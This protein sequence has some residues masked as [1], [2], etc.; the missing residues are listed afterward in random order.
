MEEYAKTNNIKYN[1]IE[2]LCADER[3]IQMMTERMDTLQQ[4]LASYERIKRFTLLPKPFSMENGELTN[5]LKL[6]RAILTRNFKNEIE[7]MYKE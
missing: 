7:E 1:S 6:R 4:G 3:I 2:E 5:T